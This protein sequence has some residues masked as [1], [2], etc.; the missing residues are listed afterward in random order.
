MQTL[1]LRDIVA[2]SQ[3]QRTSG[4]RLGL[5]PLHMPVVC[6][7]GRLM[8]IQSMGFLIRFAALRQECVPEPGVLWEWPPLRL[9]ALEWS[10]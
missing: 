6:V 1:P 9:R 4:S 10:L 2:L 7:L 3:Q 5:I 8:L